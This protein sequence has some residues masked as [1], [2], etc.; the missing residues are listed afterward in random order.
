M[1]RALPRDIV[2]A[3]TSSHS[4][5]D[6]IAINRRLRKIFL[7]AQVAL[8][9]VPL[10]GAVLLI[11][12]F[13][14]LLSVEHGFNTDHWLERSCLIADACETVRELTSIRWI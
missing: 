12:S 2:G 14:R 9:L 11:Q 3:L 4:E 5:S 7:I 1:F 10:V 6:S 13:I 8:S